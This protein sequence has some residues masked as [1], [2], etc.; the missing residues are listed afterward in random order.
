VLST[1]STIATAHPTP[2]VPLVFAGTQPHGVS[3]EEERYAGFCQAHLE[4]GIPLLK[5]HLYTEADSAS[6]PPG[7]LGDRP[8]EERETH[9]LF[10]ILEGTPITEILISTALKRGLA[11]PGN[12][13][14]TGFDD[15][16][17]A[18]HLPVPLTTVA[19]PTHAI[20]RAAEEE[21]FAH[22]KGKRARPRVRALKTTLIVRAS[23][24][25]PRDSSGD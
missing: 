9:Y 25:R 12:Y 18:S 7:Y 20:G 14:I 22:I 8:Q 2:Y 21:L 24:S 10:D 3:S 16:H 4:R 23:T 11:V 17:F 6:I 13:S 19:P 15:L 5:K 1:S